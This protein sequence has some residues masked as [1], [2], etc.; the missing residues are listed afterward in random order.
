MQ[1]KNPLFPIFSQIPRSP[2]NF[3]NPTHA[4]GRFRSHASQKRQ[5][6]IGNIIGQGTI[7]WHPNPCFKV[8][9]PVTLAAEA[10]FATYTTWV[11]A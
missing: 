1:E 4:I 10:K 5:R 6:S 11:T 8:R 9:L 2:Y 3:L 7:S